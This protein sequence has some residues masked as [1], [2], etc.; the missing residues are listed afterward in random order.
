MSVKLSFF[1][2]GFRLSFVWKLYGQL[3]Y[4]AVGFVI[5]GDSLVQYYFASDFVTCL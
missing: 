2:F 3:S 5:F 4:V 1:Y